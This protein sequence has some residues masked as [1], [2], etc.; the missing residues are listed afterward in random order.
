VNHKNIKDFYRYAFKL[1]LF[2]KALHKV[3]LHEKSL[4]ANLMILGGNGGEENVDETR[5]RD[6]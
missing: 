4:E 6:V 2:S 3:K 1:H 5:K